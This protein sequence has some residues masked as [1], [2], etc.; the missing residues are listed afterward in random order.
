M[1]A[2]SHYYRKY[3]FLIEAKSFGAPT[4]IALLK[5]IFAMEGNLAIVFTDNVPL[6]KSKN[7]QPMQ[8]SR[9]LSTLHPLSSILSQIDTLNTTLGPSKMHS[10]RLKQHIYH[11]SDCCF[12]STQHNWDQACQALPGPSMASWQVFI[13]PMRK[14]III[15]H[16]NVHDALID[17]QPKRELMASAD[18]CCKIIPQA[19]SLCRAALAHR[20][21]SCFCIPNCQ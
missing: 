12:N 18:S 13:S 15:S 19:S 7:A 2:I 5:D 17:R 20:L 8:N 14:T 9:D 21:W 10:S 3:H 16:K 4:L 6:F 1:L 11:C